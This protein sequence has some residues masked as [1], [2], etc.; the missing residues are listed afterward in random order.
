MLATEERQAAAAEWK[1]LQA[2]PSP[3]DRKAIG[4]MA[5]VLTLIAAVAAPTV[6]GWVGLALEPRSR[7]LLLGFW[8]LLFLGG[9]V[10]WLFSPGPFGRDAQR[11][12]EALN[13]L[14]ANPDG[15]AL[16]RRNHAVAL[17]YFAFSSHGPSTTTTFD[18]AQARERL[19]AALPYV[20]EVETA[21][22]IDQKIYR[23]FTDDKVR[24]PG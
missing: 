12:E 19:G 15:D 5:M 23:V 6:I 7:S 21:L 22:A 8:A 17:L 4:C 20:M 11:A 1:R 16:L 18:F 9:A 10:V 3:T 13:W 2:E 24:L 14:A